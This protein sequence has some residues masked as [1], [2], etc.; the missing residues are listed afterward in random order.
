MKDEVFIRGSLPM[1]K[2]EVRAVSLF[3]L[4]LT[5]GGVF[6]DIGAGTGSV[7]VEAARFFW[8]ADQEGRESCVYAIEREE[9]GI[10]LIK[11]NQKKLVP[12]FSRFFPVLG[13]APEILENLPAPSHVF[14]GGSGGKLKEI[15]RLVF[16]K[17]PRARVVVNAVTAESCLSSMEMIKQFSFSDYEIVQVSISRMERVGRYHMQKGQN[18]VYVI[19][20]QG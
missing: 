14:I 4:E 11:M 8:Q 16:G 5:A 18:P 3:K 6:W 9:K 10:E 12:E 17:N 7:A 1:T 20:L 15:V 13:S 2:S 19:T